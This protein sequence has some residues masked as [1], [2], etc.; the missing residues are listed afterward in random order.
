MPDPFS[1]ALPA[2]SAEPAPER[3]R[4]LRYALPFL[5]LLLT[6]GTTT[7]VGARLQF[8]FDRHLEAFAGGD[9]LLPL[10]PVHWLWAC[11]QL[12]LRGIPFSLAI[13]GILLAHELGHYAYCVRNGVKATLPFFIPAPTLIG[14]LG[15][16]IRIGSFIRS[17]AALFDI[18]ISGP[19]AGFVVALPVTVA[20]LAWSRPLTAAADP[21]IQFGFPLIFELCHRLLH[22]GGPALAYYYLHPVALAGWAGMLATA[23]NLLPGGQLDGGH[24]VFSVSPSLHKLC[25]WAV[26]AGLLAMAWYCWAGWIVWAIMLSLTALQQPSVPLWPGV[27]RGRRWM[28]LVALALLLLTLTPAPVLSSTFPQ[29]A[30]AIKHGQF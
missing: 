11:P 12:L 5:L 21:E 28:A 6:F 15:A 30:Y 10:F 20:G 2:P 3:R 7:L 23:L 8:N 18:G 25:S 19:I 26:V 13:M 9:E 29:V 24:I 1:E 22:P 27:G 14:T 4:A 16:F 17:R